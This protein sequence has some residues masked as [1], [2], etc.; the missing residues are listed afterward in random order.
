MNGPSSSPRGEHTSAPGRTWESRL[1]RTEEVV[2][3]DAPEP[4]SNRAARRA[5]ARARRRRDP[6]A[7]QRPPRKPQKGTPTPRGPENDHRGTPDGD[8]PADERTEPRARVFV[9]QRDRDM[10]GVSGTGVVADGVLWPDGTASIRWRGHHPSIVFWSGGITDA[11]AVHGHGGATRIVWLD[12][13]PDNRRAT[14]DITPAAPAVASAD[15]TRTLPDTD[16]TALRGALLVLLSRAGRGTLSPAD[17]RLLEQHVER[18]LAER[19]ALAAALDHHARR[20]GHR[21]EQ[22]D[23]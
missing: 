7:A 9:L 2:Q 21:I 23:P 12:T 10:S 20:V 15:I 14:P 8:R 5:E 16:D 11:E 1:V 6:M 18:L 4:R 3:D 17:G 19:D 22:T 13:A